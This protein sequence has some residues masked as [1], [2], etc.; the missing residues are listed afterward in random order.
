MKPTGIIDRNGV[1]IWEG[2]RVS[3]D[4]NMTADNSMGDLP[5]GWTFT[6]DDVYA[7]YFD[8]RIQNWSLR[9][10]VEPDSPYNR[11]YMD[12]AVSL[13]HDGVVTVLSPQRVK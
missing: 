6:E 12:H 2:D 4:G 13:L 7:V 8:E 1:E 11:K 3:L 9:L 10:G 5:N